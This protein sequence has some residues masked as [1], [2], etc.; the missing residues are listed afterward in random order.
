MRSDLVACALSLL[1]LVWMPL[2]APRQARR[3]SQQQSSAQP[4]PHRQPAPR[5]RIGRY[6]RYEEFLR[7][8]EIDQLANPKVGKTGERN[9]PPLSP[10][11]WLPA[12]R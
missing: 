3:F 4:T 9:S 10:A 7:T 1:A 8:V 11:D 12:V 2:P 6:Q 5:S